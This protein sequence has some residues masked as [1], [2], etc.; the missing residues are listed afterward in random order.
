MGRVFVSSRVSMVM[1]YYQ[2]RLYP[3]VSYTFMKRKRTNLRHFLILYEM[4]F[5]VYIYFIVTVFTIYV[6][7]KYY[8]PQVTFGYK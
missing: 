7:V 6:I 2:S 3:L 4:M 1:V 8:L 5:T